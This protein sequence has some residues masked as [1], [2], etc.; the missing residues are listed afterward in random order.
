MYEQHLSKKIE[1]E[2]HIIFYFNINYYHHLNENI[3]SLSGFFVK[4][5]H[6]ADLEY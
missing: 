2:Q 5:K 3:V 4:L 6:D 1:Y